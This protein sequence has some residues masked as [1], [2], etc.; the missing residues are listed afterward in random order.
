MV[1]AKGAQMVSVEGGTWSCAG[2]NSSSAQGNT[3][4]V[5][6]IFFELTSF[7]FIRNMKI[8]SCGGCE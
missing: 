5:A 7:S 6:A 1:S 2:W 3:T 4:D 8:T